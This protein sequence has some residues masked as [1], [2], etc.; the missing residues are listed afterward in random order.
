MGLG[1]L[2]EMDKPDSSRK[3]KKFYYRFIHKIF[4]EQTV[5]VTAELNEMTAIDH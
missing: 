2:E 4:S 5:R 1:D 3:D